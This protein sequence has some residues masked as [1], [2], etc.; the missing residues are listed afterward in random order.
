MRG[1]DPAPFLWIICAFPAAAARPLSPVCFDVAAG[2]LET[3]ASNTVDRTWIERAHIA[4]CPTVSNV[5]PNSMS[6]R[7]GWV[8]DFQSTAA[9][10]S[11][12]KR[13]RRRERITGRTSW[14]QEHRRQWSRVRRPQARDPPVAATF[15]QALV[16]KDAHEGC[17]W[18]VF[19]GATPSLCH[20]AASV[21]AG[22][23]L[24]DRTL[25]M[26]SSALVFVYM[27]CVCH[28]CSATFFVE[29][30]S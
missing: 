3:M 27:L 17:H 26:R 28:P 1:E 8:Y 11:R 23:R 7:G 20:S 15:L 21:T 10:K 16:P 6:R 29:Y 30:I 14:A 25:T 9:A 4:L 22:R 13:Q 24:K 19:E 18:T 2:H 5:I 12:A